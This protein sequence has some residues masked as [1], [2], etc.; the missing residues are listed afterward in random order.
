MG[1]VIMSGIVPMLKAPVTGVLASSLAVGS[2]VKLMEGGA[3]VEYLVVNQGIPGNSSL[4]D[5]SCDG[6]WL[7]RKDIH[8][9]RKWHTRDVNEYESSAINTWLNGEFFNTLGSAEQA[10]I[11]QVKIPYR[12]DG[13]SY[14]TDQSG[15]NGL[16]CKVFLLSGYEVGWTT[17]DYSYCPVDGAKLSYFESGTGTPANNKRIANL[18]G[19]AAYW[20]LRSPS[21]SYTSN[22]W[23]VYTDG[24]YG[25]SFAS[26]S[27]GIRPALVLPSNALF[28]GKTMLLK[29][30][31]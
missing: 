10:A 16:S 15:A 30:V 9:D 26:N 20:W 5:A 28:D 12:K 11:K 2:T 27:F 23:Y 18:N 19:S 31:A 3:A 8:S 17:S 6:T 21:T 13:G 1:R 29:E 25:S 24:G 4:Y 14:G 7:L 22:V